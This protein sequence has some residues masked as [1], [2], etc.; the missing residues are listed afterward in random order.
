MR[1]V[2]DGPGGWTIALDDGPALHGVRPSADRLFESVAD[3][4]GAAS[5]GVVLT[6]MGKDGA[7]GLRA[8]RTAGGAGIVQDRATSTIY[9]MPQAAL[10]RAGAERVVGLSAVAPTIVSLLAER[11][12]GA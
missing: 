5:I 2:D 6:G 8:I 7:E 12:V 4:F 1:V 9:G 3:Q 10:K 11:T